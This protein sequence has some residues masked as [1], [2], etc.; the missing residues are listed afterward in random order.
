MKSIVV[1]ADLNEGSL[2][3]LKTLHQDLDLKHANIHIVHVFEIQYYMSEFTP[4][5]FP[6]ED[7]YAAM[8]KSTL[9]IL[10]KLGTDLGISAD[11][12]HAKCFFSRSREDKIL[13]YLKSSKA[14]LAVVATRGKHGVEG[15]LTTSLTD[16]LC[17]YSPCDLLVIRPK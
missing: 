5:V 4:Y 6:T 14:D 13:E 1:C 16:F 9:T 11:R 8:E 17:K 10:N 7:Q 3:R 12:L 15:L 2:E